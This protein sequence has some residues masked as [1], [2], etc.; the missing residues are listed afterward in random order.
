VKLSQQLEQ[1]AGVQR[2]TRTERVVGQQRFIKSKQIEDERLRVEAEKKRIAEEKYQQELEV[3]NKAVA[4]RTAYN[5]E[6]SDWAEARRLIKNNS[7]FEGTYSIRKKVAYLRELGL[8]SAEHD[9]A[10]AQLNRQVN[11]NIKKP[12]ITT[13]PNTYGDIIKRAEADPKVSKDIVGR[14]IGFTGEIQPNLNLKKWYLK[15]RYSTS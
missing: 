12:I 11:I 9:V 7:R 5:K 14:R 8:R 4:K 13:D 10:M 2:V 6:I 1:D 3:Y 15:D